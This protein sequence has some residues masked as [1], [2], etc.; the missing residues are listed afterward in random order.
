MPSLPN[1]MIIEGSEVAE[2]V[3][4]STDEKKLRELIQ[5]Q[6]DIDG[7]QRITSNFTLSE[8]LCHSCKNLL[9]AENCYNQT[10]LHATYADLFDSSKSCHLCLTF[11]RALHVKAEENGN[12]DK[13]DLH[14]NGSRAEVWGMTKYSSSI[15]TGDS[16]NESWYFGGI[17]VSIRDKPNNPLPEPEDHGSGNS[18]FPSVALELID[19]GDA[20]ELIFVANQGDD[21]ST[22]SKA[23][24]LLARHWLD[25]CRRHHRMCSFLQRDPAQLPSRVIDV[26][27]FGG[28]QQSFLHESRGQVDDYV[29][30]SHRWGGSTVV[31]T[32]LR[33]LQHRK[34]GIP[35]KQMPKTFRDAVTAT[36]LLGIRYLWIDSLCVVQDHLGDW[37]TEARAMGRIFKGATLTLCATTATCADT[38][39]FLSL[40]GRL[41]RPCYLGTSL[42]GSRFRLS[43][44]Q[45][46]LDTSHSDSSVTRRPRRVFLKQY[47]APEKGRHNYSF[48]PKGPLN[49]RAWVLQEE[50]LSL[51]T[52][53]FA[54]DSIYWECLQSHAAEFVPQGAHIK[55]YSTDFWYAKSF[56]QIMFSSAFSQAVPEADPVP[57]EDIMECWNT[58]VENFSAR[59]LTYESDTLIALQG[60][61]EIIKEM[62]EDICIAGLWKNH[63][64]Q[65]LMWHIDPGDI[66]IEW[67]NA[68][69][70]IRLAKHLVLPPR[71][72]GPHRRSVGMPSWS[73]ASTKH[74][75]TWRFTG[76]TKPLLRILDLTTIDN[77]TGNCVGRLKV[78][79][80]LRAA[81]AQIGNQTTRDKLVDPKDPK[82]TSYWYF[83]DEIDWEDDRV[84]CLGIA[85]YRDWTQCLVLYPVED[86]SL[87]KLQPGKLD[88]RRIGF[89]IWETPVWLRF[90]GP[91]DDGYSHL[92]ERVKSF[93][94]PVTELV[95]V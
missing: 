91:V 30:L 33:S 54:A 2:A 36:R 55:K 25:Q 11:Y 51:R 22:G 62:T 41:N 27:D 56:K 58:L 18:Q 75:V 71:L 93:R 57:L 59:D 70:G 21:L 85:E 9:Q 6:K 84:M 83:C 50:V 87:A 35:I 73:W 53:S 24:L 95:I 7:T 63:L 76:L 28:T 29:C 72:Q 37:E 79:G 17:E 81:T 34:S 89:A 77:G 68:G 38:G 31:T 61:I 26:G 12:V 5:A 78:S 3:L 14:K 90:M 32:T 80:V 47:Q 60:I 46:L 15:F 10:L 69:S 16:K 82:N 23:R 86:P 40:D 52:V 88:F 13:I 8:S 65:Q 19:L 42:F 48:C 64:L 1:F 43:V 74:P 92:R 45:D 49:T 4:S 39:L 67:N 20:E 94:P 44:G 66:A